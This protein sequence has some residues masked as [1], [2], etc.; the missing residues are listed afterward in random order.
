MT[1]DYTITTAERYARATMTSDMTHKPG[2]C[3]INTLMAAGIAAAGSREQAVAL[4]LYRVGVTG[5]RFALPALVDEI[6]GWL[7]HKQ[8]RAIPPRARRA[9][10]MSVVV[11]WFEPTCRYCEG[12]CFVAVKGTGRLSATA[13]DA[14]HGTGKRP[15]KREVAPA[16]VESAHWL[17]CRLDRLIG[18]IERVMGGLLR[19]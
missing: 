8:R 14:C 16:H 1:D 11:W 17:V 3:D 4:A 18:E 7:T 19:I 15:L 13:C 9:L 12:R 6:A 2:G 5:D 10:V